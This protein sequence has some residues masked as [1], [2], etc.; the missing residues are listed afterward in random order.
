MGSPR[1]EVGEEAPTREAP[2][3]WHAPTQVFGEQ[4]RQQI[5]VRLEF[6]LTGRGLHDVR[7]LPGDLTWITAPGSCAPCL[8]AIATRH[9]AWRRRQSSRAAS[10][11]P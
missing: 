8:V 2:W 4:L 7:A 5:E 1:E 6:P 3:H 9:G 11:S 10:A